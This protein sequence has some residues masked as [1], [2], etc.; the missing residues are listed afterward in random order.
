M[1]IASQELVEHLTAQGATL[2]EL[3]GESRPL[4]FGEVAAEYAALTT[5]VAVAPVLDVTPIDVTG[6]DRVTL[7]HN[8]CTNDVKR[9]TAGQGCEALFTNAQGHTVGYGWLYCR[10]S[11]LTID[12]VGGDA[13]QLIT[14]LDRYV[15]REDVAFANL[16]DD[17]ATLLIVGPEAGGL[18]E[19]IGCEVPVE[20]LAHVEASI[21]LDGVAVDILV[22]R[23][24]L[25]GRDSFLLSVGAVHVV[26]LW[27]RLVAAGAVRCGCRAVEMRRIECGVPLFG[28]DVTP[29]NLPQEM[30]RD[31]QAISFTKG[32]Y[33]GQETVARIDAR[34]HVNRT[35]G[36]LKFDD[37]SATL[38]AGD[39][40]VVDGKA[41]ATVTSLTHSPALG[42]S[43][44]LAYIRR[45]YEQP[46]TRLETNRG[47]AEVV[48]LPV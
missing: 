29:D 16:A 22:R 28:V 31:S 43:L 42:A 47:A 30:A 13:A 36:G 34:G 38:S 32:C 40:L 11:A 41:V 24:P 2:G 21:E 35:L 6:D 18:L 1:T 37:E 5:G 3:R 39:E 4:D 8:M 33:I 12:L 17:V 7:L 19:S 10:Q 44:A 23:V 27:D 46:G 25:T 14:H 48:S 26:G 15:I 45:G 9:L 20:M